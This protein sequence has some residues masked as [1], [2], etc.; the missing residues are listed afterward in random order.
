MDELLILKQF[1]GDLPGPTSQVVASAR[2][3]LEVEFEKESA[4][5]RNASSPS[6]TVGA[7]QVRGWRL[8]R[9]GLV[10]ACVALTAAAVLILPGAFSGSGEGG[11]AAARQL[12]HLARVAARQPEFAQ[13]APDQFVY[14]MSLGAHLQI[15][16]AGWAALV[17]E[18][19]ALWVSPNGSGRLVT[20]IKAPEFLSVRDRAAWT[21][22]G[23]PS[24]GAGTVTD[25]VFAPTSNVSSEADSTTGDGA[26]AY[27]DLSQLPTDPE[28]LGKLIENRAVEGGP[29][30]DAESLAIVG[31]LLRQQSASPQLRAALFS[32]ASSLPGVHFI[33]RAD[34]SAGRPGEVVAA[35]E[36]GVR[37]ELIIDPNTSQLL[38]ERDVLVDPEI[39]DLN[40]DPGAVLGYIA[41]LRSGIVDSR[42]EV[43]R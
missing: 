13:P 41:Y 4:A 28:T 35:V 8:S 21:H 36:T 18:D 38:G 27:R 7:G 1:R 20:R 33:G 10:A 19:R 42:R 16:S 31:D 22:N 39:A 29:P 15:S 5:T 30:G 2:L 24:L 11:S 17:P 25:Q 34:D 3:A 40:A 43:P 37:R 26:L 6:R 32:V 14:T 9:P 12:G 23:S